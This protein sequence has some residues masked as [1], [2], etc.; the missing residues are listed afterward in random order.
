MQKEPTD[1]LKLPR[2]GTILG[3][4]NVTLYCKIG[5]VIKLFQWLYKWSLAQ[6][7]YKTL[8]PLFLNLKEPE[9]STRQNSTFCTQPW[10]TFETLYLSNESR[11]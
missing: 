1:F 11:F 8:D 4:Q 6:G 3:V 9:I 2:R 10:G 5:T 7:L